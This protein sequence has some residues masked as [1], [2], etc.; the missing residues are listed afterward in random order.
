MPVTTLGTQTSTPGSAPREA[1]LK[2]RVSKF[3][4]VWRLFRASNY[5]ICPCNDYSEHTQLGVWG[6]DVAGSGWRDRE[7][8]LQCWHA[9][10]GWLGT[11]EKESWETVGGKAGVQAV[12]R[13][14]S[15]CYQLLNAKQNP[16]LIKDS[17]RRQSVP[18]LGESLAR[19]FWRGLCQ[20]S[21]FSSLW[22]NV[23]GGWSECSGGRRDVLI[24]RG[25]LRGQNG[26]SCVEWMMSS[27]N[28]GRQE[29]EECSGMLRV[30]MSL[31]TM[32]L[33]WL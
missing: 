28:M 22:S 30:E 20:N 1:A 3:E 8:Y 25:S 26:Q 32:G 24:A 16:L 15:V 7:G 27:L 6:L 9:T 33:L 10:A 18:C 19:L 14:S 4:I 31:K 13:L 23:G 29:A 17:Q 2:H 12:W 5:L 21:I 11:L